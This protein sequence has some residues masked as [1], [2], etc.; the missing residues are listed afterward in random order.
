L[1]H[2]YQFLLVDLIVSELHVENFSGQGCPVKRKQAER[3]FS[4]N[5]AQPRWG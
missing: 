3:K 4:P 1:I 5:E 2:L